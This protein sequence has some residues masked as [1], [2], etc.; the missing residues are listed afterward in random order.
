MDSKQ[1]DSATLTKLHIVQ[2]Q[3]LDEMVRIC[4]KYNLTYFL[5]YGT[6]LGA[7]RHKGF[8]PWD[9]D[10]DIT[11]PRKD[12]ERFLELCNTELHNDYYIADVPFMRIIPWLRLCKKNTLFV[13]DYITNESDYFGIY[14]DIFPGDNVPKNALLQYLRYNLIRIGNISLFLKDGRLNYRD[15]KNPIERI[16]AQLIKILT[17]RS[18]FSTLFN[19]R[20]KIMTFYNNRKTGL[21]AN[22]ISTYGYKKET[23]LE[24]IIYPLGKIEFEGKYYSCP[25]NADLFL[26]HVYGDYMQVPPI[27]ERKTHNPKILVIE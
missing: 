17:N 14:I 26:K 20:K 7:V 22:S 11:M 9:D 3:I 19:L 1:L 21:I 23:F 13:A 16:I 8:I 25:N 10:I 6:L 27:E 15:I 12:Y 18:D 24:S 4:E 2:V 5:A